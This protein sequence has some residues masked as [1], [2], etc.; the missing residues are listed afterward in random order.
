MP[1]NSV[2]E[3]VVG[4]NLP[5]KKAKP[6]GREVV[7][8]EV[9]TDD[10][11]DTESITV[12]YPRNS[13][14]SRRR[15]KHRKP[16]SVPS[17]SEKKKKVTF[18]KKPLKPALK[19]HQDA[20]SSEASS[21][22]SSEEK[23]RTRSKKA[24]DAQNARPSSREARSGNGS[25]QHDKHKH[26][27]CM[28]EIT[29]NGKSNEVTGNVGDKGNGKAA[30]GKKAAKNK[31]D[32]EAESGTSTGHAT[33]VEDTATE[34][35]PEPPKRKKKT[36]QQTVAV[37]SET[38]ATTETDPE[39]E[40][41]KKGKQSGKKKENEQKEKQHSDEAA[42]TKNDS[43][44]KE[45]GKASGSKEAAG[46]IT[47][48]GPADENRAGDRDNGSK[49]G[50]AVDEKKADAAHPHLIMPVR[51][52]S[53]QMEHVVEDPSR[54]APPNAH[55]DNDKNVCRV[56]HG[57]YWGY[58]YGQP[59]LRGGLNPQFPAPAWFPVSDTQAMHGHREN[60]P[61]MPSG[62]PP[63]PQQPAHTVPYPTWG[64]PY[65][66]FPP[67]PPYGSTHQRPVG[68]SGIPGSPL[69]A[70]ALK[71]HG[72]DLN[73]L[74][75]NLKP[76]HGEK[77]EG[78]VSKSRERHKTLHDEYKSAKGSGVQWSTPPTTWVKLPSNKSK[79]GSH[80][81]RQNSGGTGG[82][83]T[84]TTTTTTPPSPRR[85]PSAPTPSPACRE[86]GRRPAA[87]PTSSGRAGTA[88]ITTTRRAGRTRPL[89]RRLPGR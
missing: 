58:P 55:F 5:R 61:Q 7:K 89:R 1:P 27:N 65:G 66:Q 16:S 86:A 59:Y 9:T 56:Y 57:P 2:F 13:K 21:G 44:A 85:S 76:G 81:A 29:K 25:S 38:E 32:T 50:G 78:R 3:W 4:Q 87:R 80:S 40:P 54:D 67:A 70:E 41:P 37:S 88:A 10:E 84:T 30:Q 45:G 64:Q 52:R 77:H 12:T 8:I 31:S 34:S 33:S 79:N 74:F 20:S 17:T 19:K 75:G 71:R 23:L 62:F 6:S 47:R 18:E 24:R 69:N 15:N 46:K 28:E 82:I 60:A 63:P 73:P 72:F 83:K 35:E 53:I 42:G 43:Q 39:S 68:V 51:K 49:K 14:S 11:T 36:K 48:D 26:Q 22:A